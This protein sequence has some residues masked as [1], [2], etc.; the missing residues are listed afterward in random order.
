MWHIL[1]TPQF[2]QQDHQS[3]APGQAMPEVWEVKRSG[4][5][6]Q[7]EGEDLNFQGDGL[8]NLAMLVADMLGDSRL[9]QA[10]PRG[11]WFTHWKQH[12]AQ[13]KLT[14]RKK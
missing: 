11:A 1:Q 13:A 10:S 2:V 9:L 4:S 5:R 8:G 6:G 7:A 12:L 14:E 3:R